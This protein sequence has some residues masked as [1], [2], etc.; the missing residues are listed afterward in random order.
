MPSAK[1]ALAPEKPEPPQ[2]ITPPPKV[3]RLDIVGKQVQ[4]KRL[5]EAQA[6]GK[7][8]TE[9]EVAEKLALEAEAVR[10]EKE[11]DDVESAR[12]QKEKEDAE[13]ARKLK[14]ETAT[15]APGEQE[16]K[17]AEAEAAR[18]VKEKEEAATK[19]RERQRKDTADR[20][21]RM[22][23]APDSVATVTKDIRE[24]AT[25]SNSYVMRIQAAIRPNIT[26]NPEAISGNPAVDIQ[27]GLAKDGS[28]K[29]RVIIRSSGVNG[30]D[31]AA[32]NALD[33]TERLPTDENGAAPTTIVISM[34]PR[35]R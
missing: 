15:A 25:L 24:R 5:P 28:I 23:N 19:E 30:W 7:S 2:A 22:A 3:A 33:K 29:S 1:A 32:L 10:K 8:K 21:A 4:E 35:D 26:F 18:K 16:K 6:A 31:T 13:V 14:E 9:K 17:Q 12:R 11:K 27:V 34:R 20:I